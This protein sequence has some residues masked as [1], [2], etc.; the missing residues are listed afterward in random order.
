MINDANSLKNKNLHSKCVAIEF[1]VTKPFWEFHLKEKQTTFRVQLLLRFSKLL[2]HTAEKFYIFT[3]C[4]C[5][6]PSFNHFGVWNMNPHSISTGIQMH[7]FFLQNVRGI[8]QHFHTVIFTTIETILYSTNVFEFYQLSPLSTS[9][10]TALL[11][12]SYS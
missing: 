4:H 10:Q 7:T 2:Y 12:H 3:A 6:C 11:Y 9:F 1:R 5:E 8:F